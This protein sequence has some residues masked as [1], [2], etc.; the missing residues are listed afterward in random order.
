MPFPH[1]Q[2]CKKVLSSTE[3]WNDFI[4]KLVPI[5][6][7][8]EQLQR[9]RGKRFSKELVELG[10]CVWYLRLNSVGET[11]VRADGREAS[12]LASLKEALRESLG[13]QKKQ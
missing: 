4:A 2:A 11:S 5:T 9:L 6:V 12:G 8:A 13:H 3:E 10:E 7:A 1:V